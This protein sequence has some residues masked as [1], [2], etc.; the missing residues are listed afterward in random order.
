LSMFAYISDGYWIDIGTPQKYTQVHQD[1]LYGRF[2][3]P[4]DSFQ[5]ASSI[6]DSAQVDQFS[7]LAAGVTV[8]E[9]TR[10]QASSIGERCRIGNNAAIEGCVIWAGVNIGDHAHLVGCIIGNDCW[11]GRH[12]VVARG[13]VLGDCSTVTDYSLLCSERPTRRYV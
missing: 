11:I 13:M 7:R 2:R 1:I 10:I 6:S 4:L 9:G 8:G 5:A 12:A 3:P